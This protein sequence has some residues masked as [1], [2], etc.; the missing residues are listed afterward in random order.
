MYKRSSDSRCCFEVKSVPHAA[1]V[2]DMIVTSIDKKEICLEKVRLESKLKLR[3]Q[4][5][6]IGVIGD[7]EGR[8]REGLEILD[9]W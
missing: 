4:A 3:L 6:S 5:Q 7:F 9:I 2:M 8:E 1:E